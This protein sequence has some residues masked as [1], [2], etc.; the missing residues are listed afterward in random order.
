MRDIYNV[1]FQEEI[2]K[3]VQISN[4]IKRLIESKNIEDGEKLPT[5]R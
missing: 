5:I 2:P 1:I 4:H 3:Y